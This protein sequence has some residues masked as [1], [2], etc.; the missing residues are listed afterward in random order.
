MYALPNPIQSAAQAAPNRLALV[1]GDTALTWGQLRDAVVDRA[2]ALGASVRPGDIV[3]VSGPPG[4][5]WVIELHA[6]GWLGA[7]AAPMPSTSTPRETLQGLEALRLG[8]AVARELAARTTAGAPP[9]GERFWPLDEDRV[10]VQTSGTTGTPQTVPLST[11]Q[12]V[13]AAFGS[14]TRLGVLPTD[15][16]LCALPLHHVGGLMILFRA[17]FQGTCVELHDGFDAERVATRL[18]SGE[19][20]HTS[21]VPAMLARVLDVDGARP[22]PAALR[23]VLVGGAATSSALLRRAAN[24]G[25]PTAVTWG[26]SESASQACTSWPGE[27]AMVPLPFMRVSADADGVLELA[28]PCV[29]G[30]HRT[31]DQGRLENGAVVIEGRADQIII[32]GGENISPAEIEAVLREHPAVADAAVV[33][34]P[35]A[36]WGM[37]PVAAL[38][39]RNSCARPDLDEVRAFCRASLSGY[40]L[41]DRVVWCDALPRGELGKLHYAAVRTILEEPG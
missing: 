36:K 2:R 33:G 5:D 9:P 4:P 1:H 7:V 39:A 15:R 28:G 38:V 13:F 11:G 26:M 41:P 6:L 16:W 27:S 23:A 20:S 3:P 32:S 30:R 31:A 37:R 34:M 40:K 25:L 14:A 22:F 8:E 29:R 24:A 12:L 18:L 17:A 10:V 35:D 21:L 19:V